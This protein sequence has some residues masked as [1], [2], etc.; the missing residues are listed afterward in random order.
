MK[1][2]KVYRKRHGGGWWSFSFW[3][4]AVGLVKGRTWG[5]PDGHDYT[6]AFNDALSNTRSSKDVS[7]ETG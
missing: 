1:E 2:I 3:H 6:Q 7:E 4:G 5:E